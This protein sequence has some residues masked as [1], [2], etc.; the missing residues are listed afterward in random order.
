MQTGL[1]TKKKVYIAA[2]MLIIVCISLCIQ[3]SGHGFNSPADTAENL[4]NWIHLS[5]GEV[6]GWPVSFEKFSIING[7]NGYYDSVA[8]FKISIITFLS[9][10]LLALAGNLFQTVF[11]NPLAAPSMLGVSTG[12]RLGILILVMEY[13]GQAAYMPFEKYKYCYLAAFAILV[14]II[15]CARLSSGR[16]RFS[17]FDLLIIAAIIN[18]IVSAYITYSSYSMDNDIYLVYKQ[19]MDSIA[20]NYEAVSFIF[21]VSA[22]VICIIPAYLIRFSFNAAAFD[23]DESKTMGIST[24]RMKLFA[25]VLGTLMMTAAM[26][27]CGSVGMISLIVPFLSRGMFGA[28]SS[29]LFWGNLLLGGIVLLICRDIGALIP[30]T[31]TGVPIGSVV[32]IIAIPIFVIIVA[33]QRRTWE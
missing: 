31:D 17:V 3:T 10:M 5:L 9:G 24:G 12:V 32:E 6:F 7:L 14:F 16:N 19:I 25:L 29:K 27:H 30:F 28:E 18:Q 15:A 20:V 21:L 26:I 22:C 4:M 2:L 8:R 11:R 13:G 33:S 1:S 23:N